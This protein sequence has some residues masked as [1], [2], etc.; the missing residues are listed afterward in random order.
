MRAQSSPVLIGIFCGLSA[1]LIWGLA[2]L[3]PLLLPSSDSVA[4]ALGRYLVFGLLSAGILL[5]SRR[6]QIRGLSLRIWGTSLLFAFIGHLGYYFFLVQ[7]I[8]HAGAPIATSIIG[9]LPVAIALTGNWIRKEFPFS[10]LAAP[11]SLIMAGLILV[12]VMEGRWNSAI[13]GRLDFNLV[14]GIACAIIALVLWTSYAIANAGFLRRHPEISSTTWSNLMGIGALALS[15]LALPIAIRSGAVHLYYNEVDKVVPLLVGALVMG[16]LVSWVGTLLW[17]RASGLVPISIAGQLAVV[18]TIAGLIY[19]FIW[20]HRMPPLLEVLGIILLFGG[21][22]L[23]IQRT[24]KAPSVP[25][26]KSR[27]LE[28]LTKTL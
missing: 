26:K 19:G 3:I 13:N 21:V 8:I 18:Q 23:A 17:N 2:F 20:S 27:D 24:R 11:I 10:R 9:T 15:L 28:P 22:L 4:L 6:E 14:I 7:A 12:N 16:V 5:A 1:N 25:P